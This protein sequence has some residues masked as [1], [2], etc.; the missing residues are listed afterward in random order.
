MFTVVHYGKMSVLIKLLCYSREVLITLEGVDDV[1][2]IIDQVH[3]Y[4]VVPPYGVPRGPITFKSAG[5]KMATDPV[6]EALVT[7]DIVTEAGTDV[8]VIDAMMTTETPSGNYCFGCSWKQ[9][10]F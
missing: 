9:G 1:G 8:T 7:A 5:M 3:A 10:I 6:T 2:E 4:F